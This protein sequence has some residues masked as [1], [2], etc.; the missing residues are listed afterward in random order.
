MAN[1]IQRAVRFEKWI[2]DSLTKLAKEKKTNFSNMMNI[3]LEWELNHLGYSK[4]QYDAEV[5]GIG[6]EVTETKETPKG[7]T[8]KKLS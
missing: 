7:K 6:R 1:K 2:V 8:Q 4:S 5:Y 3:L